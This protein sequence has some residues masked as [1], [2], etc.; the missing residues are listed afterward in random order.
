MGTLHVVVVG[1][2]IAGLSVALAAS[3]AGHRVTVI[4]R[5]AEAVGASIRNFGMVW[6]IGQPS[7][8]L[9]SLALEGRQ[10]WS[11]LANEAGIW[12]N[13]CGSVFAA[14]RQ[15]EL[16]VLTEFASIASS[17]GVVCELL[18]PTQLVRR[19]P[20][21]N[22]S[23]L[24]GGMYSPTEAAV[25]PRAAIPRLAAWL[26]SARGVAFAFS[27]TAVRAETGRVV[28]ADSSVIQCDRV[29]VCSGADF[30][31]LFPD[32]VR[33]SGLRVCKLQMLRTY[34]QPDGFR[35]GPHIAGGLSFRH[36]PIFQAC[37]SLA[38]LKARLA[39]EHP[40]LDRYGIHVM[41]AQ[42]DTG[43]VILGDSHEYDEAIDPFDS[44][45]IDH[46][47][48]NQLRTL[49]RLPSW[50]IAR[51]WSGVYA[52]HPTLPYIALS[53]CADVHVLTGFGGGGMTLSLAAAAREW[54]KIQG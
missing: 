2:G 51:R 23:N 49:I 46:L 1:A 50:S 3:R 7:G 18:D 5:G 54:P 19:A 25:N 6:P 52:K 30:D 48:L 14:H 12:L 40:E 24:W 9:R 16:T 42:T 34:P 35:I 32:L 44:A 28:L 15:D 47:I 43:E 31:T 21:V 26:A 10:R 8:E 38:A 53:P 39:A 33:A 11:D 36:Y 45:E 13:P 22:P 20:A 29:V 27:T 37:P 4:E 17:L 41:A